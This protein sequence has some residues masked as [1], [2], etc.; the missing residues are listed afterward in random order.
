MVNDHLKELQF[1]KE[2]LLNKWKD[3]T[4]EAS[5]YLIIYKWLILKKG[6]KEEYL[7]TTCM[8]D[9]MTEELMYRMKN[10]DPNKGRDIFSYITMYIGF[11]FKH[12]HE[13]KAKKTKYSDIEAEKVDFN[14]LQRKIDR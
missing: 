7:S 11:A 4:L 10:Y 13:N 8:I 14:D 12:Y 6:Y 1:D 3:G 2:D 5:I 9:K